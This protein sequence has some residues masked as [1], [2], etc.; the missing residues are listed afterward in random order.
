[1]KEKRLHR[2]N[3]GKPALTFILLRY[4]IVAITTKPNLT[5]SY[6]LVFSYLKKVVM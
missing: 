1:M 2:S 4:Y 5:I 3:T 6:L